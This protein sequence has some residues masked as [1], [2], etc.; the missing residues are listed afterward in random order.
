MPSE[1]NAFMQDANGTTTSSNTGAG[2]RL[3]LDDSPIPLWL[4]KVLDHALQLRQ[5]IAH[6]PHSFPG[7]VFRLV[8][9]FDCRD[10]TG[11]VMISAAAGHAAGHA[12]AAST[13]YPCSFDCT[14]HA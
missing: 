6:S 3:V 1:M 5:A 4:A 8:Q 2:Q 11:F 12:E 7:S 14:K 9:R 13:A 10:I